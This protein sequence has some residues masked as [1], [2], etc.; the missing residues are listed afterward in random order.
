MCDMWGNSIMI[1]YLLPVD[2]PLKERVKPYAQFTKRSDIPKETL[3]IKPIIVNKE[4]IIKSIRK[5]F[6]LNIIGYNEIKDFI[7]LAIKAKMRDSSNKTH[8]LLSGA[9]STSKTV[10]LDNLVNA[11]GPEIFFMFNG[12]SLSKS[13]L[14]D[15]L[16]QHDISKIKYIGIDEIDKLE[17]DQQTVLLR[18]LES[19][20]LQETKF[21]RARTLEV[22][23]VLWFATSNEIHKVIEPLKTRFRCINM[24]QYDES[25]LRNIAQIKLTKRHNFS[26][27]T[28]K[29]IIDE[30]ISNIDNCTVRDIV[31][32]GDMIENPE[33]DLKTLI[34]VYDKYSFNNGDNK[35]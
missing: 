16:A 1:R 13:G 30:C 7:V 19:G 2:Q 24:P 28:T 4:S 6:E 15:F 20:V 25:T 31:A 21:K 27:E 34:A 5:N 3:I 26:K 18:A 17:K 33:K 11:I 35:N 8:I 14:I 9:P 29:T 23:H 32:I 10:F 22:S 12:A